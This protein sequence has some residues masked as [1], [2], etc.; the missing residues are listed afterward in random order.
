MIIDELLKL[1]LTQ[2][3]MKAAEELAITNYNQAI[4][5]RY[6]SIILLIFFTHS[7]RLLKERKVQTIQPLVMLLLDWR[8]YRFGLYQINRSLRLYL[9]VLMQTGDHEQ[10]K[11]LLLR[12]LR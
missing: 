6:Q 8:R 3:E 10:A 12:A 7:S 9:K 5:P 4:K 2:N 11:A 1:L